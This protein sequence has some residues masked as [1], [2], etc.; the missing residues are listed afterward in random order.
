MLDN[1]TGYREILW[2]LSRNNTNNSSTFNWYLAVLEWAEWFTVHRESINNYLL[3][4]IRDDVDD[5]DEVLK[6]FGNLKS[7][8]EKIAFI[9]NLNNTSENSEIEFLI[10]DIVKNLDLSESAIIRIAALNRFQISLSTF[11]KQELARIEKGVLDIVRKNVPALEKNLN[12]WN[13]TYSQRILKIK[14]VLDYLIKNNIDTTSID[15][16]DD[17]SSLLAPLYELDKS[18]HELNHARNNFYDIQRWYWEIQVLSNSSKNRLE[19]ALKLLTNEESLESFFETNL[20][21]KLDSVDLQDILKTIERDNSDIEEQLKSLNIWLSDFQRDFLYYFSTENLSYAKLNHDKVKKETFKDKKRDFEL[22]VKKY[23][24]IQRDRLLELCETWTIQELENIF[25]RDRKLFLRTWNE[26]DDELLLEALDEILESR[27]PNTP[28]AVRDWL[29]QA[30]LDENDVTNE[31]YYWNYN[32]LANDQNDTITQWIVKSIWNTWRNIRKVWDYTTPIIGWFIT[33]TRKTIELWWK[34]ASTIINWTTWNISSIVNNYNTWA[35]TPAKT[36][37]WKIWKFPFKASQLITRPLSWWT[38]SIN[39]V[40]GKTTQ[41]ISS[42]Y[43]WIN[44]SIKNASNSQIDSL[45]DIFTQ[46]YKHSIKIVWSSIEWWW[47]KTFDLLKTEQKR[48]ILSEFYNSKTS[49]EVSSLLEAIDIQSTLKDS[50]PYVFD[51]DWFDNLWYD[52]VEEEKDDGKIK[53]LWINKINELIL[54]INWLSEDKI[55]KRTK[56]SLEQMKSDFGKTD[57][58]TR[59][60]QISIKS[61]VNSLIKDLKA[62]Y[63]SSIP[64]EKTSL[65]T[66]WI[67]EKWGKATIERDSLISKLNKLSKTNLDEARDILISLHL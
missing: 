62:M 54:S 26:V 9:S 61:I 45:F 50:S 19:Q 40:A 49:S 44:E 15:W 27:Y 41:I 59:D 5:R 14:E 65:N 29:A 17:L 48:Q 33:L 58:E 3:N 60:L 39:Y 11:Q 7:I 16:F 52:I 34:T 2:N 22:D 8:R 18:Y 47:D 63:P 35:N 38:N 55:T 67:I 4:L 25:E 31:L 21:N 57:Y 43:N 56:R 1:N 28:I 66:I 53:T 12:F 42:S 13:E 30:I 10:E 32:Y 46:A 20:R 6:D 37:F 24:E 36:F 51:N 64:E 23:R